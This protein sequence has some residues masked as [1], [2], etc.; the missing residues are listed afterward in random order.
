MENISLQ[1]EIVEK[2]LKMVEPVGRRSYD[3]QK[4]LY[5]ECIFLFFEPGILRYLATNGSR[6]LEVTE[7]LDF[8]FPFGCLA[9]DTHDFYSIGKNE[10]EDRM[11]LKIPECTMS[12]IEAF[13]D[14]ERPAW[15]SID[16]LKTTALRLGK[17]KL[18][19]AYIKPP[20]YQQFFNS[21][22]ANLDLLSFDWNK[23]SVLGER[24]KRPKFDSDFD[25]AAAVIS[26]YNDATFR[27]KSYPP[28]S[29]L[30]IGT[31]NGKIPA[32]FWEKEELP[33]VK[34]MQNHPYRY[35]MLVTGNPISIRQR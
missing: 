27:A 24:D 15:I 16:D 35:R 29:V 5:R 2:C 30:I 28:K 1:P 34:T 10:M 12:N 33:Q 17:H 32:A 14:P 26:G 19:A 25:A 9:I 4:R 31:D 7:S 3:W 22:K 11:P 21:P 13:N 20:K 8:S 6:L 18:N 23:S